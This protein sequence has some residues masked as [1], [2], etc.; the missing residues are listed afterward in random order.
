L[1]NTAAGPSL[2]KTLPGHY[3]EVAA[4]SF[5]KDHLLVS[6]GVDAWVHHYCMNTDTLLFR[7]LFSAPPS[8]PPA[9]DICASPSALLSL[10]VDVKGNLRLFDLQRGKKIARLLCQDETGDPAEAET[11]MPVRI[12][13]TS[14]AFCVVCEDLG[15]RSAIGEGE[16]PGEERSQLMLFD[17]ASVLCHL[18]PGIAGRVKGGGGDAVDLFGVLDAV[19]MSREKEGSQAGSQAQGGKTQSIH[20]LDSSNAGNRR[21]QR[22]SVKPGSSTEVSATPPGASPSPDNTIA[23]LTAGNLA[24]LGKPSASGATVAPEPAATG[25][26]SG[27]G[28]KRVAVPI[29]DNWQANI[30]KFLRQSVHEREYRNTRMIKR[31]EHLRKEVESM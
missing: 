22:K 24:A 15:S 23:T 5:H 8:P 1:V 9:A 28:P 31:M 21:V 11:N 18:Y 25:A 13:A 3:S 29:P 14:A 2:R 17:F 26:S 19:D 30:K 10:S 6:V 4:L 27:G 12:T 16:M 7:C 20:S